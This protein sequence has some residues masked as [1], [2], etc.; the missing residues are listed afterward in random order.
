MS[1]VKCDVIEDILPLYIDEVCREATHE[2][3]EDH[4]NECPPC[5]EK[6][7]NMKKDLV[8]VPNE[9]NEN[10]KA[11]KPFKKLSRLKKILISIIIILLLAI[12]W[13]IWYFWFSGYTRGLS[14]EGVKQD[15]LSS[16]KNSEIVLEDVSIG[17]FSVY[18]VEIN[19]CNQDDKYYEFRGYR[20]FPLGVYTSELGSSPVKIGDNQLTVKEWVL[21][22]GNYQIIFGNNKG[23]L[24][25]IRIYKTKSN[26]SYEEITVPNGFFIYTGI[27]DINTSIKQVELLNNDGKVFKTFIPGQDALPKHDILTIDQSGNLILEKSIFDEEGDYITSEIIP[28]EK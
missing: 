5:K 23:D 22:D 24:S 27:F 13:I 2:L 9:M 25:K 26:E 19:Y 8:L 18:A 28:I 10:L 3:V 20:K 6:L 1:K 15:I 21:N 14:L 11:A 12:G 17:K 4:L 16:Y 7:N